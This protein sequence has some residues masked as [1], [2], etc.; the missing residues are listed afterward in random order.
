MNKL[1]PKPL[2]QSPMKKVNHTPQKVDV[3]GDVPPIK[4]DINLFDVIRLGFR[5]AIENKVFQQ[6]QI[7]TGKVIA[8]SGGLTAGIGSF[9][10]INWGGLATGN[11][12]E[13]LKLI[14]ALVGFAVALFW[15]K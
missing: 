10:S 7:S 11:V 9:A 12:F 1:E 3:T 5:K 8:V 6:Y 15:K 13:W 14:S 2:E 4:D